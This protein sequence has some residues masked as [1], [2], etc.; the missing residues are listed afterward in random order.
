MNVDLNKVE[1]LVKQTEFGYEKV[2]NVCTGSVSTVEW[3][4]L[5]YVAG[6]FAVFGLAAVV[7]GVLV[8]GFV[9]WRDF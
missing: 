1:C 7:L 6:S 9:M 4:T 3:T 5:D 8:L 2:T